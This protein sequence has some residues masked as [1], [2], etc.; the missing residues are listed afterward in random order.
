MAQIDTFN[1]RRFGAML[2]AVGGYAAAVRFL[3]EGELLSS[4]LPSAWA[5]GLASAPQMARYPQKTT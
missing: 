1:R 5:E 4:L 3:G 2:A